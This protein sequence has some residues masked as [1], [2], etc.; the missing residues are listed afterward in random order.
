[1]I[2]NLT[3][4]ALLVALAVPCATL[5][6]QQPPQGSGDD[7]LGRH[8]FPPELVMS[9]QRAIGLQDAQR[10]SILS[11]VRRAQVVF[12]EMQMRIA[13]EMER[14]G[15]LLRAPS[16]DEGAALSQLDRILQVEYMVKRSH[17]AMLI[18]VR[19]VLTAGQRERLEAIRAG[20]QPLSRF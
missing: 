18:R 4:A 2:R 10:D 19:N 5:A 13:G 8:L 15:E 9:N 14:L 3:S 16:V 17:I 7:P 11:E 20:R 1:M 12:G 6:Q